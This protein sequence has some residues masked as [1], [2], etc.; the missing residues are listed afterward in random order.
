MSKALPGENYCLEHQGNYS[1]YAKH[2]CTVCKLEKEIA[3][4]KAQLAE[5]AGEC[6]ECDLPK[7]LC[8][9]NH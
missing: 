2:N 6:S 7:P 5:H 1:H 3:Q 8:E 9:C 4:L